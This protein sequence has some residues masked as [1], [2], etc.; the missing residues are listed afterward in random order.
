[1]AASVHTL[2]LP[3]ALDPSAMDYPF[4][5]VL[6]DTFLFYEAQRSGPISTAPGGNRITW[7]GDHLLDDGMD[8]GLDLSGGHYEAGSTS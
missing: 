5:K 1:V 8:V 6:G 4:D 7:R 3:H 2:G